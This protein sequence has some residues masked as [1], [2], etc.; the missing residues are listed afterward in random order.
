MAI[1]YLTPTPAEIEADRRDDMERDAFGWQRYYEYRRAFDEARQRMANERAA[2][3]P[4][5]AARLADIHTR[6]NAATKLT[7][8]IR[9]STLMRQ[10]E[11]RLVN[12]T[13]A[14]PF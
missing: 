4:I 1:V 2:R 9:T 12:D 3:N 6:I 14:T 11:P 10:Q 7:A 8:Q 13:E 5:L